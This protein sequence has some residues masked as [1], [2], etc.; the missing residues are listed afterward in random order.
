MGAIAI[1]V[2]ACEKRLDEACRQAGRPP[3]C[4]TLLAVSKTFPA[5]AVRE[6]WAAG[7]R[8]FGESYVQEALDKM[9]ELADL[10]IEWH[11]IGPLQSNKT[12]PVAERFAWVHGVERGQIAQRLARQRPPHLPALNVCIQV[13]VSGETSKHGVPLGEALALAQMVAAQPR[14]RLRGFMAIPE[15]SRDATVLQARFQA[16]ADLLQQARLAGFDL[17]TLSMGMSDD[18]EVAVAAGSTLVRVGSAIFGAR[19][20][21]NKE[22]K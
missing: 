11:F 22:R 20:Q 17:D 14:L 9:D 15:P 3:S 13:N 12:R 4:A 21:T 6:A 18:L 16:L 2:Q 10:A 8:R 5:A 7:Q 1:A 19:K